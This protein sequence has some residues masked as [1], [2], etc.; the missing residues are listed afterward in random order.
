M[1]AYALHSRYDGREITAEA[2]AVLWRKYEDQ[3]DPD[4]VLPAKER[5]RRAKHAWRA[6]GRTSG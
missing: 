1:S 5:Q 2:R 3:V 6:G 4:R